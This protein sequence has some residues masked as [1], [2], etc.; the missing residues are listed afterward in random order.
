MLHD[1]NLAD[2]IKRWK[3]TRRAATFTNRDFVAAVRTELASAGH[4]DIPFERS[5]FDEDTP[6]E[7]LLVHV[8]VGTEFTV[9]LRVLDRHFDMTTAEDLK[10]N[11]AEFAMALINLRLAETML[12]R[13]AR[14]VRKAA[15]K[16]VADARAEGLD[17][18]LEAVGFKPTYAY[19]LNWKSWKDAAAHVLAAVTIRQTSFF[20]RPE[21]RTFWVEEPQDVATE[22]RD[23]TDDQRSRQMRRAEL[24]RV[25]ADLVVD[26]VTL[27]LLNCHGLDA[28]EVL[29][30]VWKSQCVNLKVQYR[31]SEADMSLV[32]GDGDVRAS[33]A[34]PEGHWNGEHLWFSGD[35]SS[36]DHQHLVGGTLGDLLPHPAF[37]NRPVVG[38]KKHCGEQF[39]FDLSDKLLFD[40]DTGR[41]WRDETVR[42]GL[43]ARRA[44]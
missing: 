34:L 37:T 3:A 41:L 39:S 5:W 28:S 29:T 27:D 31:G 17:I 16:A 10:R 25:G 32:T 14:E 42:D 11:A 26:A 13:Y 6:G 35:E 7:R 8:P 44:A 20:L 1:Y 40:G 19:H 15:N 24:D 22:M 4:A 12:L 18:L 30:A 38:I 36:V 2:E 33:I 21:S 43:E 9:P 23:V